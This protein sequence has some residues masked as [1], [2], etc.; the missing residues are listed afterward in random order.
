MSAY[1]SDRRCHHVVIFHTRRNTRAVC[2]YW[3]QQNVAFIITIFIVTLVDV[4]Y[5][6]MIVE[7]YLKIIKRFPKP[8]AYSNNV[9]AVLQNVV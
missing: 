4:G 5:I 9:P 2:I 1:N 7:N 8:C 6:F 3:P